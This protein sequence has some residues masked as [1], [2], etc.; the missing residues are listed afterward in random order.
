MDG[1][2]S[3][4]GTDVTASNDSACEPKSKAELKEKL[5]QKKIFKGG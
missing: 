5:L 1:G 4:F 2:I 3:T